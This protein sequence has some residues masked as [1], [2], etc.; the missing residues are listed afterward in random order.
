MSTSALRRTYTKPRTDNNDFVSTSS[1]IISNQIT[2]SESETSDPEHTSN[3]TIIRDTQAAETG[4]QNSNPALKNNTQQ[5]SRLGN[6]S[7]SE[8]DKKVADFI[9]NLIR[10]KD[11]TQNKRDLLE[12]FIRKNASD[13]FMRK[14]T[15]IADEEASKLKG[16]GWKKWTSTVASGILSQW[17]SFAVGSEAA[18]GAKQAWL[19]PILSTI[20]SEVISDKAAALV[21]RTTFT[22]NDAKNLYRKQRLIARA[23]G[24]MIRQ[25]SG[26]KPEKKYRT[27]NPQYK[28]QKFTAWDALW[29]DTDSIFKISA[30]NMANRG[31]PFTCF[32]GV[33]IIRDALLVSV[34][35]GAPGWQS[36]LLRLAAGAAA[37]GLTAFANQLITGSNRDATEVP[38]HSTSFWH[39]K[40]NYLCSIR[41]DIRERLNEAGSLTDDKLKK[42]IETLLLDLDGKIQREIEVARLKKSSFT[43]IP[44]EIK[45][46]I[47]RSRVED[48]LDPELP[49]TLSQSIHSALGKFLSLVFFTYLLDKSFNSDNGVNSF[50][51]IPFIN[52][53]A[54]PF[55]LIQLG[56]MW[57]DDLQIVSRTAY[58]GLKGSWDATI[59]RDDY[60]EKV[61]SRST[62]KLVEVVTQIPDELVQQHASDADNT[63]DE[64]KPMMGESAR[65]SSESKS[66]EKLTDRELE[67]QNQKRAQQEREATL[68]YSNKKAHMRSTVISSSSEG[69]SDSDESESD[70]DATS[71]STSSSSSDKVDVSSSSS[72]SHTRSSNTEDSSS[73]FSD[74]SPSPKR[75]R[76][77]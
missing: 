36:L 43:A 2:S 64:E 11:S 46:S 31:A 12:N 76:N 5:V 4:K 44:G 13:S 67:A 53:V 45:A 52:L 62:E 56:W 15:K 33:Y 37:G 14:M 72:E 51:S 47:H 10:N 42:N 61:S 39:A 29:K 7:L 25:C 68:A 65:K 32:T 48:S 17:T 55:V 22:T 75:K 6:E 50:T 21:R 28:G 18:I 27:N 9:E 38:G 19:F 8:A 69:M 41:E 58:G 30:F 70:D 49:G 77:S 54:L 63:E 24:D 23:F 20:C 16:S 71:D 57:R 34:L 73:T 59:G 3:S 35:K 66:E 40:E 60:K 1:D 26:L 74:E